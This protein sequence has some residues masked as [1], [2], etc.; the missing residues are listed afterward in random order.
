[1]RRKVKIKQISNMPIVIP[2]KVQ[3]PS[4]YN[5]NMEFLQER[6]SRF[7]QALIDDTIANNR[8]HRIMSL[9][10]VEENSI[11]L[12]ESERRLSEIIHNHYHPSK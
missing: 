8:P 10:E 1:L 9:A 5:A 4:T 12:E 7:A 3:A 6:V 11:S 2:I